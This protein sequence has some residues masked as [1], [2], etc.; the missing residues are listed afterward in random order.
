MKILL[1]IYVQ[2]NNPTTN[3]LTRV[4]GTE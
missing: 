4:N 1:H 2:I 3:G